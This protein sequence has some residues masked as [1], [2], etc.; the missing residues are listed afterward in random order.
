MIGSSCERPSATQRAHLL[1][2]AGRQH[3]VEAG[4]DGLR[5]ACA[6]SGSTSSRTVSSSASTG[7]AGLALPVGERPPGALQHLERAHDA[8]RVGRHQARRHR[9]DRAAPGSRAAR[10]PACCAAS[11]AP[12]GAHV[13]VDRRHRREALQQHLEIEPGAADDDGH[14]ARC[15]RARAIARG[16]I[17]GIA[18][19]RIGLAAAD[20]AVERMR[21]P[22]LLLGRRPRREDAQLAIDLHAVGIDDDA[23]EPARP[24]AAQAPTCRWPSARR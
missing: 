16:R 15:S 11:R 3:G 8:L 4:V 20:E 12:M 1:Q 18:P 13:G 23:A 17:R 5:R 10:A 2:G 7:C 21:R 14:A 6:R 9:R 24:A 19:G 22:R